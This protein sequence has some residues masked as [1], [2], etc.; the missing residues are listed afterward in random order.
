MVGSVKLHK[1]EQGCQIYSEYMLN[2][3]LG[4]RVGTLFYGGEGWSCSVLFCLCVFTLFQEV[5]GRSYA[6]SDATHLSRL[7]SGGYE[8]DLQDPLTLSPALTN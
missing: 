3:C 4:F 5:D 6:I 1:G 2:L 8:S 7:G